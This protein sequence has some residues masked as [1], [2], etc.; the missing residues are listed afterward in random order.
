MKD[1]SNND[2]SNNKIIIYPDS[3]LNDQSFNM[4]VNPLFFPLEDCSN[5]KNKILK[6]KSLGTNKSKELRIIKKN[7]I[8]SKKNNLIMRLNEVLDIIKKERSLKWK[9]VL[10]I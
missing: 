2:I 9:R 8:N 10:K 1:Q 4:V 6:T 7:S 3:I 5:N